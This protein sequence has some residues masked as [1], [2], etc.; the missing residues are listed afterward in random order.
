MKLNGTKMSDALSIK[1]TYW[2]MD[3]TQFFQEQSYIE[4]QKNVLH[5]LFT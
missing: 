1:E 2:P 5:E 4:D 3:V